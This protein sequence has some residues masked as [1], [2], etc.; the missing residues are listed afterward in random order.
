MSCK[1]PD[2][3]NF[4]SMM[5]EKHIWICAFMLAGVKNGGVQILD[6]I[7]C[8]CA[9]PGAHARGSKHTGQHSHHPRIRKGFEMLHALYSAENG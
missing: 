1:V 7:F 3:L 4:E 6:P 5:L 2:E 8:H 9:A